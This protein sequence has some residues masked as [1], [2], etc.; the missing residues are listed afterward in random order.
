[1]AFPSGHP[2]QAAHQGALLCQDWP[3]PLMHRGPI[4]PSMFFSADDVPDSANLAGSIVFHFACY[5]GGTPLYDDFGAAGTRTEVA[6]APFIARLPQRLLGKPGG[7]ALAVI[8]HVERA[9][10]YSFASPDF[11]AQ[12]KSFEMCLHAL[13]SGLRVGAA[14]DA[15]AMR[16][17]ALAVGLN[18]VLADIRHGAKVDD[19]LLASQW[20][21]HNDARNYV[22][23]GDPAVRIPD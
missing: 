18:R 1:M 5:G 10:S 21:M 8:G 19:H 3:G 23:L 17:A 7:G 2:E 6:A 20:T 16:H 4:D 14:M 22:I 15:F 13:M 12:T 11:G 9:W